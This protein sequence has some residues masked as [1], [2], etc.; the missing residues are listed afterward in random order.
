VDTLVDTGDALTRLI[1]WR[2]GRKRKVAFD[3][4]KFRTLVHY[5]I[6][7]CADPAKLGAV[8]LNKVLWLADT[9]AY[10]LH[11][12]P[13]TGATYIREKYGPVAREM[14]PARTALEREGY[15]RVSTDEFYNR[16]KA[17]FRTDSQPNLA[18]IPEQDRKIVDQMIQYVCE[19]H[20]AASISEETHDY[21]WEIA[22]M[23]EVIPYHAIFAARI[24]E[25]SD[26]EL[27]WAREVARERGLP[28]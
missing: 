24:Q 27:A 1:K 3:R 6:W 4:E 12:Q 23:G 5:V 17:V 10:V 13:M 22:Q 11:G 8:K 26:E 14:M 16:T 19:G 15:I 28:V 21:V 18:E 20:T 2:P 25:P 9:R 7:K